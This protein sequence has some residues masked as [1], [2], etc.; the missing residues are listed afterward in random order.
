MLRQTS[1][2]RQ[3]VATSGGG[4]GVA[5]RTVRESSTESTT[6]SLFLDRKTCE[7]D[8]RIKSL[9]RRH[10]GTSNEML[11]RRVMEMRN[12]KSSFSRGVR[13]FTKDSKGMYLLLVSPIANIHVGPGSY[14]WKCRTGPNI[15][16]VPQAGLEISKFRVQVRPSLL[17]D[18]FDAGQT[19]LQ[20]T[21]QL[22]MEDRP[23]VFPFMVL[24]PKDSAAL[25]IL[26]LQRRI[27][28]EV[29]KETRCAA[30]FFGAAYRYGRFA[31]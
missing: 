7:T 18:K 3:R 8:M 4:G 17:V 10:A 25:K 31:G 27:V 6:K 13:C 11:L 14:D 29:G 20:R 5:E 21:L 1:H 22:L 24:V 16:D 19:P 2:K 30:D 23:R 9:R 12:A 26:S 15:C 28:S